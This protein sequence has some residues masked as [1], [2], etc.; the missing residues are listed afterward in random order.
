MQFQMQ[1]LAGM[2]AAGGVAQTGGLPA[3]VLPAGFAPPIAPANFAQPLVGFNSA[4]ALGMAM[5]QFGF[6]P[7]AEQVRGRGARGEL[8]Q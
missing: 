3:T 7:G 8:V 4:G 2:L 5:Q 1:M 6:P